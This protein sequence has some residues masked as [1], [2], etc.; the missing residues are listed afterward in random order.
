MTN[1]CSQ[2]GLPTSRILNSSSPRPRAVRRL[3]SR[4]C[5]SGDFDRRTRCS[6]RSVLEITPVAGVVDIRLGD[7]QRFGLPLLFDRFAVKIVDN[8]VEDEG[9]HRDRRLLDSGVLRAFADALQG[10]WRAIEPDNY[11]M[12]GLPG[13]YE[14][15]GLA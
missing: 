5:A 9:T 1:N 15:A 8:L 10:E 6:S 4:E 7:Q 3:A 11:D 13:R 12:S 14:F 2:W